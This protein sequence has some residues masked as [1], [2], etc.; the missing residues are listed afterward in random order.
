MAAFYNKTVVTN[1]QNAT[2]SLFEDIF[3]T[4]IIFSMNF[5]NTLNRHVIVLFSAGIAQGTIRNYEAE[6]R[7]FALSKKRQVVR[8]FRCHSTHQGNQRYSWRGRSQSGQSGHPESGQQ[9]TSRYFMLDFTLKRCSNFLKLFKSHQYVS[10][11]HSRLNSFMF[12][13]LFRVR[14]WSR[15]QNVENNCTN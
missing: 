7:E 8:W 9:R 1:N 4:I 14:S 10:L 6:S 3:A 2:I 5:I 15:T 11:K 13:P 12:L